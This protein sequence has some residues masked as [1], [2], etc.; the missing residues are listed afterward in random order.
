M[1]RFYAQGTLG[2]AWQFLPMGLE[3]VPSVVTVEHMG[4][5]HVHLM[6]QMVPRGA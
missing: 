5:L 2:K 3:G 6:T 4:V 1:F